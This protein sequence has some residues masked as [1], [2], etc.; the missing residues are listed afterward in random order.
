MQKCHSL[1]KLVVD[2]LFYRFIY[3]QQCLPK[4]VL[5]FCQ[6]N[7]DNGRVFLSQII[8]N[9]VDKCRITHITCA[10]FVL[11]SNFQG[12]PDFELIKYLIHFLRPT[13][14]QHPYNKV[15]V[16][17]NEQQSLVPGEMVISKFQLSFKERQDHEKLRG[18]FKDQEAM[19]AFMNE[20]QEHVIDELKQNRRIF[21]TDLQIS[22][23][24]KITRFI[25]VS[26]KLISYPFKMHMEIKYADTADSLE[27]KEH[28]IIIN[29]DDVCFKFQK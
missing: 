3:L 20:H 21:E 24:L 17:E 4:Q 29:S 8:K 18:R 12:L 19:V 1:T 14:P 23:K 15:T 5:D 27:A 16:Q 13:R 10:K 6:F 25:E 2:G 9:T 11:D 26:P 22:D 7:F 28:K